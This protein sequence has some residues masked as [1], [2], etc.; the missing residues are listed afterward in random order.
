MN[1]VNAGNDEPNGEGDGKFSAGSGPGSNPGTSTRPVPARRR[2]W[3]LIGAATVFV[4]ILALIVVRKP[5]TGDN[6]AAGAKPQVVTIPTATARVGWMGMG[7]G[8][9]GPAPPGPR[10]TA[11]GG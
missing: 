10:S 4:V 8:A 9:P 7:V 5:K 3:V 2:H 1:E 11:T 6:T